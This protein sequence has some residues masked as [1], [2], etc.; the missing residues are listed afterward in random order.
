MEHAREFYIDGKWVAPLSSETLAVINPATEEA[1]ES[2][3][4]GGPDDVDVAVA[5]ARAAFETVLADDARGAAGAARPDHRGL[6]GPRGRARRRHQPGDG[7]AALDGAAGPGRR[8]PRPPPHGPS[9]AGRVRLRGGD[10]HDAGR[11]G[12]DRRVRADHALELAAE[13]DRLQGRPRPRR[14]LHHGAE[15][16]RGR[17]VERHHLRRDPRRGRRARRGVQPGP[18]RRPNGRRRR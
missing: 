12:A 13:P 15:A 2:I 17:A 7:R 6:Q 5:A 9:R 4:M 10:G 14:G 16:V 8:R 18:R 11:A 3:A 1:I